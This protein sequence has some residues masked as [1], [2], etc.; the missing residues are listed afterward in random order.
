[1]TWQLQTIY[2]SQ[3]RIWITFNVT[4]KSPLSFSCTATCPIYQSRDLQNVLVVACGRKLN[5]Q[6]TTMQWD[7][8]RGHVIS[9]HTRKRI[10]L[11]KAITATLKINFWS[12]WN[13]LSPTHNGKS[14]RDL[15]FL[16]FILGSQQ[17]RRRRTYLDF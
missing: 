14:T 16:L 15:W 4:K 3:R 17:T 11:R 7:R 6:Y 8:E 1:M 12:D 9:H 13:V 2:P 5:S 10:H